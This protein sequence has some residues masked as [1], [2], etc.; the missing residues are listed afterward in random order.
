MKT[1]VS[2][3][4][5]SLMNLTDGGGVLLPE[6]KFTNDDTTFS[7][8]PGP[9]STSTHVSAEFNQN[10]PAVLPLVLKMHINMKKTLSKQLKL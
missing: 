4:P 5:D 6:T 9:A 8:R 7:P 1:N 2:N 3:T 10:T